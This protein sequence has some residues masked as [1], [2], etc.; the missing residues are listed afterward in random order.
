MYKV[1]A[2]DELIWIVV[3]GEGIFWSVNSSKLDKRARM[4][5]VGLLL[6]LAVKYRTTISVEE[7]YY[8]LNIQAG[9]TSLSWDYYPDTGMQTIK[10]L[11]E[12]FEKT[13]ALK[14]R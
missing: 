2:K 14:R 6:A 13:L 3:D 10:K 12:R 4:Y 11:T 7:G 1:M 9:Q 8:H 5:A